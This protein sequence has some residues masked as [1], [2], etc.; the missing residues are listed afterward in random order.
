MANKFPFAKFFVIIEFIALVVA[1]CSSIFIS[2]IISRKVRYESE[3]IDKI[4]FYSDNGFDL[5]ISGASSEQIDEFKTKDFITNTVKLS[6]ISLNVKTNSLEDYRNIFVF[7]SEEDLSYSEFTQKR[8]ISETKADKYVY[9]DYNFCELYGVK[10][11]DSIKIMV[12]GNEEMYIVS[13]IY[14]TDYLYS[15]G[16]IIATKDMIPLSDK[17]L[18]AYLT[19]N[20]KDLLVSYLQDYKPLGTLLPKTSFQ[21]EADY[22][23]YLDDFNNKRYYSSYVTDL[24]KESDN[25]TDGYVKKFAAASSAFR[26]SIII[27]S[28]LCLLTSLICFFAN[29]KNKKDKIYKY[30]QENGNKKIFKLF[31]VFNLSFVIFVLVGMLIAMN[32]ALKQLTTYYTFTNILSTSYLVLVI[33]TAA[34]LFGYLITSIKIKKA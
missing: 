11:G 10:L 1:I 4:S 14:R 22:Q 16:V 21:S 5:L 3:Y 26:T 15:D 29:A 12:N 7:D 30:I 9:V 20:N 2:V 27:V 25:V 33:P 6:K 32:F 13:R 17:S 18:H 8:I 24:S 34:I 31:T 19:T 28:I 23:R